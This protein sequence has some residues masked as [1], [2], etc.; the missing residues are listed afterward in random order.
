EH[1]DGPWTRAYVLRSAARAR[2]GLG[3][4]AVDRLVAAR[5]GRAG[6]DRRRRVPGRVR[7]ADLAGAA[8]RPGRAARGVAGDQR[9]RRRPVGGEAVAGDAD[10]RL[11]D[12]RGPVRRGG[13]RGPDGVGAAAGDRARGGGGGDGGGRV[14]DLE[15]L[16]VRPGRAAAAGDRGEGGGA[17]DRGRVGRGPGPAGRVGAL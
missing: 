8:A 9:A 13:D 1:L 17:G 10:D 15:A 11:P 5:G 7:A 2:A 14:G 12:R 4:P 3:G 6:A 16:H